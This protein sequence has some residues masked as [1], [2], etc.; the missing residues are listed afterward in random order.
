MTTQHSAQSTNDIVTAAHALAP[1]VQ[2]SLPT[3]ET[4]RRLPTPLVTALRDLGAFRLAV[5]RAYGGLEL[6]PMTQ[7]RVVEELFSRFP[8]RPA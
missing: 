3:M 4:E 8:A 2:G 6:D 1:L 7:V 5:P